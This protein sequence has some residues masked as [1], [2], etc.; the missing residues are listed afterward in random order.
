VRLEA[1]DVEPPAE[2]EFLCPGGAAVEAQ[3]RVVRRVGPSLPIWPFAVTLGLFTVVAGTALFLLSRKLP[4]IGGILIRPAA[5]FAQLGQRPEWSAPCG[6]ALAAAVLAT[7]ARMNLL[8]GELWGAFLGMPGALADMLM[9]IIPIFLFLG[10]L[11]FAF[12][13]WLVWALCLWGMAQA[14][15]SR[16]RYFHVV[17]VVGYAGIPWLLGVCVASLATAWNWQHSASWVS[18]VSGLGLWTESGDPLGELLARVELFSA[19][20][21]MLGTVGLGRLLQISWRRAAALNAACWGLYLASVYALYA[22]SRALA[23]GLSGG[24]A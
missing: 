10:Y 8:P 23:A 19:W 5:T 18:R 13:G 15:G 24:G 16:C 6:I 3:L 22:V 4:M 17:S 7:I 14:V 9:L 2:L 21:W 11:V 1:L 20:T 12:G